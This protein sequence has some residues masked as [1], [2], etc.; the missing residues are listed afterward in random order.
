[1]IRLTETNDVHT[2][3]LRLTL[4]VEE[5]RA[6]WT[7]GDPLRDPQAEAQQAFEQRWFGAASLV[8]TRQLLTYMRARFG[9][10]PEGF[11]VLRGLAK[12]EQTTR[13]LLCHWHLQFDDPIYRTFTDEYLLDRR[14][15][16]APTLTRDQVVGWLETQFPG[17]WGAQTLAQ[18]GRKLLTAASEAGLVTARIDPR[19]L[20]W[21][22][23]SDQALTYLFY[24]LRDADFAGTLTDNPYLRC[25]GLAGPVLGDRVRRLP[26]L[27]WS[28]VGNV[29][30]FT[31]A[32][33]NLA[34]WA[35]RAG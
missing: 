20:L 33:E 24:F 28:H 15:L 31:W 12:A 30:E 32:H 11:A 19:K 13:R 35:R 23:V 21:P 9:R 22:T 5:S 26:D 18:Y 16:G 17:R 27:R 34:A 29:D 4:A 1:M 6:Y 2:R 10:S 8:R 3:L 25:V 7:H 14:E